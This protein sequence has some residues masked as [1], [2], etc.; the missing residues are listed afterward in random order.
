MPADGLT[1]RLDR[2]HG[3]ENI[4]RLHLFEFGDKDWFPQVLHD[5]ETAFLEGKLRELGE[6]LKPPMAPPVPT[7]NET[8]MAPPGAPVEGAMLT[9]PV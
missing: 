9:V 1:N 8:G 2:R 6:T 7:V 5:A 4:R 3:A